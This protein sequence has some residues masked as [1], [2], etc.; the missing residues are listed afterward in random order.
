MPNLGLKSRNNFK[1]LSAGLH[2]FA[3][4]GRAKDLTKHSD[5]GTK[6]AHLLAGR[7]NF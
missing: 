6:K 2:S 5:T 7:K 3:E 1:N 4:H